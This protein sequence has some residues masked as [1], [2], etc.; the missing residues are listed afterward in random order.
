[1]ST[2]NSSGSQKRYLPQE[3][4]SSPRQS[5]VGEPSFDQ[6][7]KRLRLHSP[8]S[9][10]RKSDSD[11]GGLNQRNGPGFCDSDESESPEI[12]SFPDYIKSCLDHALTVHS[13]FKQQCESSWPY[14]IERST[15]LSEKWS[16]LEC[17]KKSLKKIENELRIGRVEDAEDFDRVSQ[18]IQTIL[19]NTAELLPA[20]GSLTRG[21]IMDDEVQ[22]ALWGIHATHIKMINDDDATINLG[23]CSCIPVGRPRP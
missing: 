21:S 23:L 2:K 9:P 3:Q 15:V 10:D 22:E 12:S 13:R 16:Q 19:N 6:K 5:N 18:E 17:L 14:G 4:S 8:S 20:D 7:S 1:M 11:D